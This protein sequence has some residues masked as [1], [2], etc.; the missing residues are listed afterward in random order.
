MLWTSVFVHLPED[1]KKT[2]RTACT[3]KFRGAVKQTSKKLP[4]NALRLEI[5]TSRQLLRSSVPT[6]EIGADFWER[7]ATKHILVKKKGFSVKRREA[8][9]EWGVWWGFLQERQFSEE[10]DPG[11]SVNCSTLKTEKLLSTSTSQKSA[12]LKI[13]PKPPTTSQ[14]VLHK[15]A[16]RRIRFCYV[17]HSPDALRAKG[18][19]SSEPRFSPLCDMISPCAAWGKFGCHR[20]LWLWGQGKGEFT[21]RVYTAAV[22]CRIPVSSTSLAWLSYKSV[23]NQ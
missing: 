7:D 19:L 11:H 4:H 10:I 15:I 1:N 9:S 6:S 18:A 17:W 12:L 14:K 21:T 3:E 16:L 2:Q 13:P 20:G 22:G 23:R 5:S 8:F